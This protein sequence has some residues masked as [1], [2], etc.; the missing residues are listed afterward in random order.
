MAAKADP[1]KL[2]HQLNELSKQKQIYKASIGLNDIQIFIDAASE[3]PVEM[4]I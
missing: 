3:V 2:H 1:V 4:D